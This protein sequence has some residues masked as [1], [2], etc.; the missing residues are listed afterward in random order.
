M[1]G[2]NERIIIFHDTHKVNHNFMQLE[3]LICNIE[4]IDYIICNI[5]NQL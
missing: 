3:I 1:I 5:W 2:S 4:L